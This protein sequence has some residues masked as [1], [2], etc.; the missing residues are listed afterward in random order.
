MNT[1]LFDEKTSLTFKPFSAEIGSQ[2]PPYQML[3]DNP[4]HKGI[5]GLFV[6][7]NNDA[8]DQSSSPSNYEKEEDALG[9]VSL[10]LD[11]KIVFWSFLNNEI[12]DTISYEWRIGCLGGKINSI[13]NSLVE[14]N[15]LFMSCE[16]QSIRFW[17]LNK[18]V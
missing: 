14:R 13:T 16:D 17:A 6:L 1:N 3:N 7:G 9:L 10:G 11:R 15:L 12:S 2:K 18:K 8:K 4:H 5:F